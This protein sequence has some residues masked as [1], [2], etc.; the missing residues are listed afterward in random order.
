[1]IVRASR[2]PV[3]VTVAR[4]AAGSTLEAALRELVLG[5]L[6]LA[7]DGLGLGEQ[8]AHVDSAE[9]ESSSGHDVSHVCGP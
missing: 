6:E 8:G 9:V 3:P 5:R 7:L 1:M 4:T 2:S